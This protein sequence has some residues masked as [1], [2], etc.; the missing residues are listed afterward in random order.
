MK[1]VQIFLSSYNGEDTICR[2]I[3]SI[4]N[5]KDVIMYLTIRD[6]GSTDKTC[7]VLHSYLQKYPQ[8]IRLIMGENIGWKRS[9]ITLLQNAKRCDYYGFADQD[10]YWFPEKI[11]QSIRTMENDTT[12]NGVKLIQTNCIY[13]DSHLK[14]KDTQESRPVQ[15]RNKKAVIAQEYFKGCSMLWNEEA[16]NL[17]TKYFPQNDIPHDYWVGL[18]CSWFGKVYYEK[19]PLFYHIR[20]G[21]NSSTDGN[22]WKGRLK[23]LKS[24]AHFKNSVY[25]NPAFDLLEGY[26]EFMNQKEISFL[27]RILD[28][29]YRIISRFRLV[30]DFEFRR[31]NFWATILFKLTILIGRY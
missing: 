9:F 2:Q 21:L 6:D 27:H 19:K 14:I 22:R 5:Q 31:D 4:L 7:E 15:P 16:M 30:C 3:D 18:I 8:N 23:R 1:S 28:Y 17:L 26:S 11:I 12:F 25:I 20:Y 10:D 29:R 24:L 13:T